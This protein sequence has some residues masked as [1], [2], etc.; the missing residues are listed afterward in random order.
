MAGALLYTQDPSA[1][2]RVLGTR[3]RTGALLGGEAGSGAVGH[4][5]VPE[6]SSAERPG[7]GPQDTW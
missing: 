6:P 7:P 2:R 4:V 1:L 5:A 3:G